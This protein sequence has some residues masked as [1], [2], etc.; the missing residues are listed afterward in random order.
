MCSLP[1]VRIAASSAAITSA[2]EASVAIGGRKSSKSASRPS[3]AGRSAAGTCSPLRPASHADRLD[4]AGGVSRLVPGS[5]K[6]S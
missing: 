5:P 3:V 4:P 1:C 2:A 6:S